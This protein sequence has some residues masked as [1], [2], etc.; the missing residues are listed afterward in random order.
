MALVAVSSGGTGRSLAVEHNG[1][2]PAVALS[3]RAWPWGT[4]R[5]R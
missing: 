2:Q 4:R 1:A 5:V 3:G